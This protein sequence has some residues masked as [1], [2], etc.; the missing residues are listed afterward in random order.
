ML[1]ADSC[2]LSQINYLN[3]SLQQ[4]FKNDYFLIQNYI[5]AS[6]LENYCGI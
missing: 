5:F 6:F 1:Q 2:F 3:H 4:D